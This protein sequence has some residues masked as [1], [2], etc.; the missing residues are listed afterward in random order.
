MNPRN[1][2]RA[3]ERP[4]AVAEVTAANGTL[5]GAAVLGLALSGDGLGGVTALVAIVA[6]LA[7][8]PAPQDLT[9]AAARRPARRLRLRRRAHAAASLVRRIERGEAAGVVL[10]SRN[11]RSRAHLRRTLA[12]LQRAARRSPVKSPLLVMVD[13]EGGPV[14]R[15]PG[16]PRRSAAADVGRTSTAVADGRTA[17]AALRAVGANVD[18]APVADVCRRGSALDRE[19]RCYGRSPRTVSAPGRR[20]RARPALARRRGHA[21]ALPRLRRRGHQ[22]GL[23]GPAHPDVARPPAARGRGA[24][25]RARPAS[26]AGDALHRRLSGAQP[27]ARRRSPTPGP[28][29]SCAGGCASAA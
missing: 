8:Q 10:F 13:Q 1:E 28:R 18:L 19:R 22:H 7:A 29:A 5:P 2:R 21:E 6:T 12:G 20:V 24:L 27:A 23:L 9:P 4:F 17:G 15:L 14:L 3:E 16:G 25:R 11:V 26:A